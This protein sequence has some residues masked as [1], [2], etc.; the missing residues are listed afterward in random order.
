MKEKITWSK[1]IT[2]LMIIFLLIGS[3]L[4]LKDGF[5]K[6]QRKTHSY[7]FENK[8]DY[9][10]ILKDNPFFKDRK[11]PSHQFY[12]ANA[13]QD[14]KVYFNYNLKNKS[15]DKLKYSYDIDAT[16]KGYADNDSKLIWSKK[17]ALESN[18]NLTQKDLTIEKD[19]TFN[20]PMYRNYAQ[21]FQEYYQIKM[22]TYLFVNL[23]IS[24]DDAKNY[25]EIIIPITD[26]ITEI[27]MNEDQSF[28]ENNEKKLS[29]EVIIAIVFISL[30]II[31]AIIKINLNKHDNQSILKEYK[32][33][34]IKVTIKPN[35]DNFNIFYLTNLQDLLNIAYIHNS[36][37]INYQNDY[38][39]I[40]DN[41]CYIYTI[42][43]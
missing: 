13:I 34:I 5:N 38:Y 8:T 43:E 23:T 24:T 21:S 18:H 15:K 32:N 41:N 28:L 26:E 27:T 3:L 19:F 12:V 6:E 22:N 40:I 4:L 7:Q 36:N 42:T 16:L 33:S 37:I 20:Y 1:I 35:V 29:N 17:F 31:M 9:E 2:F 10:V 30:G 39:V 25:V 14:I 11:L